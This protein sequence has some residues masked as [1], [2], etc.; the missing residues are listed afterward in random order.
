MTRKLLSL[1]AHDW[2]AIATLG[3][4]E[5]ALVYHGVRNH[6]RDLRLAE[7]NEHYADIQKMKT[8]PISPEL[9][10]TIILAPTP[11]A[12]VALAPVARTAG[13]HRLPTPTIGQIRDAYARREGAGWYLHFTGEQKPVV[14]A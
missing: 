7:A 5:L 13:R 6:R 3:L 14:P 12:P 9:E 1:L 11:A 2:R 4:V 10:R 8:T